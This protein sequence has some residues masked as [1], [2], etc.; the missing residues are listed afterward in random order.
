M[1]IIVIYLEE[2]GLCSF[3]V[4]FS[5]LSFFSKVARASRDYRIIFHRLSRRW[6]SPRETFSNDSFLM[7]VARERNEVETNVGTIQE[8][9]RALS[10][11][12]CDAQRR[13]RKSARISLFN[14]LSNRLLHFRPSV[15]PPRQLARTTTVVSEFQ[16]YP[17]RL[18]TGKKVTH[19]ASSTY[20]CKRGEKE[21]TSSTTTT[22]TT[23]TTSIG[24]SGSHVVPYKLDECS[25][26]WKRNSVCCKGNDC[27]NLIV[28]R[29]RASEL[30]KSF[31]TT[32]YRERRE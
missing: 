29:A 19:R 3:V 21:T 5:I 15:H 30:E 17:P 2:G 31:D 18:A 28:G 4:L 26:F 12:R 20:L 23:T 13:S 10:L 25:T 22:T 32:Y 16:N 8:S 27:V 7:K 11:S 9:E 6:N 1:L 24:L 14:P